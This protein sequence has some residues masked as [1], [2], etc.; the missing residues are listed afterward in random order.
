M[1][2]AIAGFGVEGLSNYKYWNTP[3]NEL[4]IVDER[5]TLDDLPA[6]AQ[7]LLGTGVFEKLDGFDMV[8]RTAGL[9]P[10]KIHT[11]GKIWSGTN[12]FFAKCPAPII[13]V[14]G[15]KGKGTTCSLITSIL[16][17]AGH[18]VH[19]VG[20]IGTPALEVL[21]DIQP[22]DI[23]VY[24]LS[25]FQLWDAER[26]PHIAVVLMIEPDHLNVH[27]D[28][29]EYVEAK[30]NITKYQTAE[31][32]LVFNQNN[33][34]SSEIA[35]RSQA[36]KIAYPFDISEYVSSL[37]LPGKHNEHNASAAIAATRSFAPTDDEIRKGLSDFTGLPH[38]LKFVREFNGVK[39]YDDSIATTPGSVIAAVNSFSER[40][41]LILGGRE[42]GADLTELMRF[43][44]DKQVSVIAIG[45]NRQQ[46][47]E[48][49]TKYDV[50]CSVESGDMQHI[51]QR[52]AVEAEKGSVVILSPAAASFD[53]FKNYA[54]RGN[55]FIAA[56]ETLNLAVTS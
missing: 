36:Q 17:A 3:E 54:D 4:T 52:A 32:I 7:T 56:V 21:P 43:C 2:I 18:T 15:T 30:A 12:E 24:E 5:E 44:H 23:V 34:L 8:I 42:K 22:D 19:L 50:K 40:V 16:R 6:G 11:D 45:E 29:G 55:Q 33:Q 37:K 14:T 46:I 51:V 38:R 39:Y 41:V 1:K 20:N 47:A 49:A 25:S 9:D 53:M 26:S 48:L 35:S 27:A 10:K 28:M 13:G 31:D